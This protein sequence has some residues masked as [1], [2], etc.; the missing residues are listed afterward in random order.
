MRCRQRRSAET[1]VATL[2]GETLSLITALSV[3]TS[4]LS[5]GTVG[6]ALQLLRTVRAYRSM[7]AAL[8]N[9]T[10]DSRAMQEEVRK[11][12]TQLGH[13]RVSVDEA[14]ERQRLS[15]AECQ[16]LQRQIETLKQ[17]PRNE[18]V[19]RAY[20]IVTVG[21]SQCGKTALTLKWANP[22][23][24]LRDV[25]PTQFVKYERTVSRQFAKNGPIVEHLFE[26]RDW[27]GEH[28]ANAFIELFTLESVNGMLIVVDLGENVQGPDGRP[29]VH[30]SDERIKRQI[31]A[32]P[33][34]T[35]KLCF[36]E[37][38]VSHCK[39][40]TLFIN[41]SDALSGELLEVE[42]RALALYAPLIN[43]L[44][45]LQAE[46]GMVD[47]EILVGSASSGHNTQNLFAHFIEKILPE[48]AYDPA[49]LQMMHTVAPSASAPEAQ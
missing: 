11:A 18:L 26:I 14:A 25:T 16:A 22:L 34:A 35:L 17:Q 1:P 41:K 6:L 20:N 48:D 31:D 10:D 39:T 46:S 29:A 37:R 27:G 5:A 40:F 7:E 13:L 21:V 43:T 9:R 32:F 24:R 47:I 8:A 49:L 36:N 2:I 30:F 4:V 15:E 12:Q 3:L 44:R 38:I 28:M 33:E 23:F 45:K 42:Q 19:R